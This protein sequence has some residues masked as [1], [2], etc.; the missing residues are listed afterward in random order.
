MKLCLEEARKGAAEGQYPVGAIVVTN[1]GEILSMQHNRI[2]AAADPT[3]HPEVLAIREAA[4]KRGS[5]HLP[6]CF[7]YST[8]EPCPMCAAATIWARVEGIVFG[9][10]YQDAVIWAQAHKSETFTWRQIL[11]SCSDIVS[12]GTPVLTIHEGGWRS[13]TDIRINR[14]GISKAL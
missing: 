2:R 10:F 7:L 1:G 4:A 5:R 12:K 6:D 14:L 9:A 11:V 8:L 13:Q 3:A